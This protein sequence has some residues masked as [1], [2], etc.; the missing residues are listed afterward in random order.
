MKKV[1]NYDP[2]NGDYTGESLADPNPMEPGRYLIPDFATTQ[3]PTRPGKGQRVVFKGGKWQA[4]AVP[5]RTPEAPPQGNPSPKGRVLMA[6]AKRNGLLSV[7]DYT[8]LP[9]FPGGPESVTAWKAYRQALR[10][11]P[12][13]P[14]FPDE[15]SWPTPPVK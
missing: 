7:T 3:K 8:M 14:G 9:D 12:T 6:R 1:Y 2:R 15:I 5:A 10:D 11:V 13:Q 4:E